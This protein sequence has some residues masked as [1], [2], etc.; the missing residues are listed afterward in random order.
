MFEKPQPFLA[1]ILA[2]G[3]GTRMRSSL[4]KVLHPLANKPLIEH[5]LDAAC[6]DNFRQ[7]IV[8]TGHQSE[9][10]RQALSH[11][12]D[13]TGFALQDS[14]KGTAHAVLSA[15]SD[16]ENTPDHH[17]LVL[18][19]D[20]PLI[21]SDTLGQAAQSLQDGADVVVL[22]FEAEDPSGYGRLVMNGDQ[23]SAIVEDREASD[24]QKAITFCNSGVMG[25][26]AAH[27]LSLLDEIDDKNSKKEFYLTD[28]VA[29]A[30]KRGLKVAA[31]KAPFE[32]VLGI[33]TRSELATA[34]K[35]F[36]ARR[37][38][39]MMRDGVSL[40]DPESVFFSADTVIDE[41]VVI[42]PNVFFAPGVRIEKNVQIRANSY[43]EGC[44]VHE[45]CVVGP[46]ARLRP[47]TVLHKG[48]RVGNFCEVKKAVIGQGSKVNHLSYIGDAVL[49][50]DVNIGAGTITCNYDGKNKYQ[51]R[52]AAGAFIGS[53]SALVAPVSIGE[54]A[55]VGAGS[56]ITKDVPDE[57]LSLA[58]GRQVNKGRS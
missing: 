16:L 10:V 20:T 54:R 43:L 29:I 35:I 11:R 27:A 58:R 23:L 2:A 52:I 39:A 42:E 8:V 28:A 53:N 32:D 6:E 19:G 38:Q 36:Q 56:V 15:R 14:M 47:G 7:K 26:S 22:G 9:R 21:T 24:A 30:R 17:I 40:I 1:V 55:L 57:A 45:G 37:R 46:F 50:D 12:D 4:P 48:A 3:Q 5:V 31:V 49:G 18:F 34:E 13:I 41:D 44:H 33:N 25:L 51:T